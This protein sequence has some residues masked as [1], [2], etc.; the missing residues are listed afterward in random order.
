MTKSDRFSTMT[1][2]DCTYLSKKNPK[3]DLVTRPWVLNQLGM[4]P[5]CNERMMRANEDASSATVLND[6]SLFLQH[7][8][9]VGSYVKVRIPPH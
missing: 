6:Q 4:C 1:V 2:V 3:N 8:H 5:S 9:R 7:V